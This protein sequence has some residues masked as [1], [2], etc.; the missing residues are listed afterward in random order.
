MADDDL[1]TGDTME[2]KNRPGSTTMRYTW[3]KPRGR[4]EARGEGGLAG[5]RGDWLGEN[6]YNC[7]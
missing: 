4:M 5:G 6:A 2:S 1:G 3:T 7:N